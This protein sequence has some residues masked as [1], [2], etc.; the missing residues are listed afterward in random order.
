MMWERCRDLAA[1]H[2]IATHLQTRV[3]RVC[4]DGDRAIAV[5]VT[6]PDGRTRR[7]ACDW[8]ISSMPI[9]QLVRAMDPAPPA[10]VLDAAEG[11]RHRD[12]LIVGLVVDR[13]E[14]FPDNWIYVHAPEVRVGRIQSFKNWSPEMVDDPSVSF[15]GLEYFANRGDDLWRMSDE[16]LIALGASEAK[17]I[18]LFDPENVEAGVVVRMPN[19]YPVY[20]GTYEAHLATIRRWLDRFSNVFTVGRNG[21][22]RYNNQDHSMLTGLYAARNVAGAGLDVWTVNVE[23]S[24]H[25]EVRRGDAAG[26]DRLTPQPAEN[27]VAD[28]LQS[29]FSY[30][31]EVAMGGA[32]GLTAT[33]A[34]V[35]ATALMLL[36]HAQGFVPMLSL[37]GN[38]LF[39]YEVS[40]PGLLVGMVEVA[41]I[42]FCGGWTVAR[43]VNV[44]T[45]AF[46][47][48]LERRLATLT[49][50]E[51]IEG[52]DVGIS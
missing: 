30:Y 17:V 48:D 23:S 24:F 44:V 16:A 12:F 5:D 34:L 29:A 7:E 39:G 10:D 45:A 14:L 8:L 25:E 19:A 6:G 4:H 46:E 21:Q 52:G 51:A 20:D 15:I 36:E 28:L 26:R 9:G 11:L 2:G 38:Y 31:D 43:L 1:S 35:V 47:R 42:G 40:W 50:L 3:T 33:L 37:L 32:V 13:A 41:L 22:H 27:D 18:G 49:T